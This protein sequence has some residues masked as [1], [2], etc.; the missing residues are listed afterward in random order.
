MKNSEL[1]SLPINQPCQYDLLPLDEQAALQNWIHENIRGNEKDM[2]KYDSYKL[3][4]SYPAYIDNGSFK[5]AM[6]AAGYIPEDTRLINWK[7]KKG[8]IRHA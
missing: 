2:L 3:K 8:A 6:L 7:F 1:A 4:R 5:G